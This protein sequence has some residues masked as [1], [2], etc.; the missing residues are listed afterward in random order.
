MA[1]D[2]IEEDLEKGLA[3]AASD[4]ADAAQ[5]CSGDL[6]KAASSARYSATFYKLSTNISRASD[7]IQKTTKAALVKVFAQSA[8]SADPSQMCY[9]KELSFELL[10]SEAGD[11]TKFH[12]KSQGF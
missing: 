7:E 1:C 2:H 8:V 5:L 6:R 11:P 10:G 3:D 12:S 4:I 9:V